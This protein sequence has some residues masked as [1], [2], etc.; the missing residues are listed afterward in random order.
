MA[1]NM[2]EYAKFREGENFSF[3]TREI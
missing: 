2:R 3:R 1:Y